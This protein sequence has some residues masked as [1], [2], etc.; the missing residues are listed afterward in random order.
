MS[1]DG[2]QLPVTL[3]SG[4]YQPFGVALSDT[5][6]YWVNYVTTGPTTGDGGVRK[7][8]RDGGAWTELT[9]ADS[10]HLALDGTS[11]YFTTYD[12]GATGIAGTVARLTPR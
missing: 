5:D 8:P 9:R 3:A 2:S 7:V 12:V 4:Q 1:T 11:V 10:F 6:V